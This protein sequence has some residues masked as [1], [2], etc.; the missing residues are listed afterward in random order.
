SSRRPDR[1]WESCRVDGPVHRP[2]R[3]HR[4]SGRSARPRHAWPT[5]DSDL[6]RRFEDRLAARRRDCRSS[7]QPDPQP[8]WIDYVRHQH[9]RARRKY[10]AER[11]LLLADLD[12]ACLPTADRH[13][14]RCPRPRNLRIGDGHHHRLRRAA[15]CDPGDTP[16][17]AGT[18]AALRTTAPGQNMAFTF[19]GAVGQRVSFSLPPSSGLPWATTVYNPAGS[20]LLRDA[21]SGKTWVETG[22]LPQAGTYN[23]FLDPGS[24]RT[25]TVTI[26]AYD[27]PPDA[28]QAITPTNA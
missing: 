15:G 23:V 26:T 27:V 8:N 14:Q 13:V 3:L 1:R 21:C 4:G 5:A 19:T 18:T 25:G 12:R 11:D 16:T 24:A 28:T 22:T 17:N 7:D 20:R 9:A 2:V 10:D 6:R